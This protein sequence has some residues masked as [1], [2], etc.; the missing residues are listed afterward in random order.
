MVLSHLVRTDVYVSGLPLI[1]VLPLSYPSL[2]IAFCPQPKAIF[3]IRF[4]AGQA[5][6]NGEIYHFPI[7]QYRADTRKKGRRTSLFL[8]QKRIYEVHKKGNNW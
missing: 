4:I 3:N 1:D 7:V 5:R 6:K 8:K 2:F